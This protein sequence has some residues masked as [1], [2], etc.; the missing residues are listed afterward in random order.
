MKNHLTIALLVGLTLSTWGGTAY[1]DSVPINNASFETFNPLTA[2]CGLGCHFNSGPIP[3]WQGGGSFQP[4]S[5]FFSSIPNGTTIGYSNGGTIA[6]TL[7][8]TV[9]PDTVYTM[10]AF[11]G[12]RLDGFSGTFT[13]ALDTIQNGVTTTLC[14][15]S[16]NAHDFT[17]GTF[18]SQSC[19]FTSGS[20]VPGGDL[21]LLFTAG[22]TVQLDVDDVSLT[23]SAAPSVPEPSSMTLVGLGVIF[24]LTFLMVGKVRAISLRA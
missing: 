19:M 21:Y 16:G 13:L 15:V 20:T 5:Q 24:L 8:S 17:P 7:T 10:T 11:V 1:A 2:T 14:T 12:N 4:N 22:H 18:E 9:L 23:T 6:Q 3:G